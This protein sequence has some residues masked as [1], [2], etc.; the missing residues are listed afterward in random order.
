MV[1]SCWEGR[2]DAP[3]AGAAVEGP[4]GPLA[5]AK[6]ARGAEPFEAA[7]HSLLNEELKMLYTAITRARVKCVFYD[8][9][10]DKRRPMFHYL[11]ALGL[12]S[13]HRVALMA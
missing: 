5:F 10:D 4:G 8:R 11:L 7:R 13:R 12:R 1:T 6:P 9:N 2:D 3:P